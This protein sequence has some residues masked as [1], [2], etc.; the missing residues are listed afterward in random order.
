M[1]ELIVTEF[2]SDDTKDKINSAKCLLEILRVQISVLETAI[3]LHDPNILKEINDK[4]KISTKGAYD[5]LEVLT[6]H[7]KERNVI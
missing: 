4:Y 6:N 1:T 3:N 2:V 5:T 7:L